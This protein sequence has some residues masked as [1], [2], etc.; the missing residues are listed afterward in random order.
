MKSE[1]DLVVR[2]DTCLPI[3][4]QLKSTVPETMS[5]GTVGIS[6]FLYRRTAGGAE[7]DAAT[8][9]HGRKR[10]R[11]SQAGAGVG[12]DEIGSVWTRKVSAVG[13]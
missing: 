6:S 5:S 7:A 9:I 1:P 10:S 13:D 12:R 11:R 2:H 3:N 4:I 8:V